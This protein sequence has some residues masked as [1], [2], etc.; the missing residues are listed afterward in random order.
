MI[1][2]ALGI[3]NSGKDSCTSLC[4]VPFFAIL[5]LLLILFTGGFAIG[6][7]MDADFCHGGED[8]T[9]ESTLMEIMQ[10]KGIDQSSITFRTVEY[11]VNVRFQVF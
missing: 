7:I 2:T 1:L 5:V 11:L 9:P 8:L 4:F 3:N 6:G 10:Y